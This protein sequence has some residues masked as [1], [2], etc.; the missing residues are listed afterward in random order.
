VELVVARHLLGELP[1][2]FV[3]EHDEV[4]EELKEPSRLENAS[5]EHF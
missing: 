4:T 1:A 5:D 3:L 2:A